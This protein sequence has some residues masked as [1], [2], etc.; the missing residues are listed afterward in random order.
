MITSNLMWNKRLTLFTNQT[1]IEPPKICYW[2][3]IEKW[4]CYD[5]SV[6]FWTIFLSIINRWLIF[7]LNI[8]LPISSYHYFVCSISRWSLFSDKTCSNVKKPRHIVNKQN[9]SDIKAHMIRV[10]FLPQK[11]GVDKLSTCWRTDKYRNRRLFCKHFRL[12]RG[13]KTSSRETIGSFMISLAITHKPWAS[14]MYW[15]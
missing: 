8:A 2:K 5:F 13:A 3:Q 11:A 12:K 9:I 15:L 4:I 6:L 1:F 14:T 10:N 7:S